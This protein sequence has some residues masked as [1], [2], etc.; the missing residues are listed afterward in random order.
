MENTSK[1]NRIFLQIHLILVLL[2]PKK[3]VCRWK[4]IV[5]PEDLCG[6]MVA[7]NVDKFNSFTYF[8][9]WLIALKIT[10]E[11]DLTL[12]EIKARKYIHEANIFCIQRTW[13]WDWDWDWILYLWFDNKLQLFRRKY[14]IYGIAYGN[15]CV[16]YF[17]QRSI[18]AKRQKQWNH[19]HKNL[20]SENG[21]NPSIKRKWIVRLDFEKLQSHCE[22]LLW[23][24]LIAIWVH[25]SVNI[26][27]R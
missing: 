27:A 17:I 26:I 9:Y 21:Q 24:L 16:L 20:K 7:E 1:S 8:P 11:T 19:K 2:W 3:Y 10:T 14:S 13:N 22:S 4:K 5:Y 6:R 18:K 23:I 12:K 15:M 25:H